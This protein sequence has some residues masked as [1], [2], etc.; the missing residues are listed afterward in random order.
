MIGLGG[1]CSK[2]A[3]GCSGH[4]V[5]KHGI[6]AKVVS[7]RLGGG[8]VGKRASAIARPTKVW[9]GDATRRGGIGSG[10]ANAKRRQLSWNCRTR[11]SAQRQ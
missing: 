5:R 1:V 8:G 3:N 9:S 2:D 7:K 11:A 6:A 10:C 4:G